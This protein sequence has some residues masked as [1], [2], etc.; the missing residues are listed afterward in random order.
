VLFEDAFDGCDCVSVALTIMPPSSSSDQ[1]EYDL[2]AFSSN[3]A[4]GEFG[5]LDC[6]S[7]VLGALLWEIFLINLDTGESLK[8]D[9]LCKSLWVMA[10]GEMGSPCKQKFDLGS[11]A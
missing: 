6:I 8:S 5:P 4:P 9:G 1:S 11:L 7:W 10:F 3:N 2:G